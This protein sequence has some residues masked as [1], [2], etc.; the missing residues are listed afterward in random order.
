MLVAPFLSEFS[1]SRASDANR[2]AYMGL[3]NMSYSASHICAPI[4][5][6]FIYDQFGADVL[7]YTVGV[8]GVLCCV[9]FLMMAPYNRSVTESQA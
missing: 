1:A 6:T 9:V 7:W 3:F 4:A 8:I 5:G 2:G